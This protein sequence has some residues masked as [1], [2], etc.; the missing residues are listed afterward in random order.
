MFAW[1]FIEPQLMFYVYDDLDWSSAQLG[2]AISAY[3]LAMM[4][5]EFAFGRLSDRFGRKPVLLL[6]LALFSAQFFGLVLSDRF[7]WITA[8]FILAGLGNA[9]F[10]P[11]LNAFFLDLAPQAHKG[12]V[13]GMKSTAGSLGSMAGPALVVLLTPYLLSQ[14][15]F[16]IS[17]ALV[18]LV[19]LLCLALL[20]T[21]PRQFS[22]AMVAPT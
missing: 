21:P 10:D 13:M 19:T 15:I 6:G 9:L 22:G 16:A 11:A 4:L 1:A 7:A 8:S 12:R 20:R 17:L 18:W 14:G 2:V 5:G 3:G